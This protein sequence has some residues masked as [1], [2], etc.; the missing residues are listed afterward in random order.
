MRTEAEIIKKVQSTQRISFH[1][2]LLQEHYAGRY[3]LPERA[4]E[5]VKNRVD[6]HELAKTPEQREQ[7]RREAE[8]DW[9]DQDLRE[10]EEEER[11]A[12]IAI[13]KSNE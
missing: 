3:I 7:E 12:M 1:L 13:I 4:L 5:L 2:H 10:I 8:I 9:L 11:E 6:E